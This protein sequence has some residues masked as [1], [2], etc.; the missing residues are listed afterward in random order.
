MSEEKCEK[1]QRNHIFNTRSTFV[2]FMKVVTSTFAT[3]PSRNW[4]M[5]EQTEVSG[6]RMRRGE[7]NLKSFVSRHENVWKLSYVHY[8]DKSFADH[9]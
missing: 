3:I 9:L 6:Q 4:S 2:V 7:P 8:T 5:R 1:R